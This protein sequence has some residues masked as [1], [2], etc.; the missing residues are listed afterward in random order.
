M[1]YVVTEPC[2]GCKYTDCVVVCPCDCFREGEQML[3]IDPDEC[4]DCDACKAECPVEA[5]FHEDDVPE[6]WK[7]FVR[8]E[9]GDGR[10]LP[11]DRRPE[12]AARPARRKVVTVA[13]SR[14]WRFAAPVTICRVDRFAHSSGSGPPFRLARDGGPLAGLIG[15]NKSRAERWR[16]SRGQTRPADVPSVLLGPIQ[17]RTAV[18]KI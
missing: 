9:S 7:E 18:S 10:D 15:A 3:F 13:G 2:F 6:A 17:K 4:I 11:A 14:I 8:P 12:G 1:A 16:G 5:I